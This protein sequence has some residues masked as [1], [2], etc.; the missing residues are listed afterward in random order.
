MQTDINRVKNSR[1]AN[2]NLC[3]E[4]LSVQANLLKCRK[5]VS[6]KNGTVLHIRPVRA[7]DVPG[8]GRFYKMLSG[9]SVFCRFASRRLCMSRDSLLRLCQVDFDR[10]FAFLAIVP[11]EKEHI[12]GEARLNRLCEFTSAE[13]SFVIADQWQGKGVG[14]LLMEFCLV[15]AKEIRLKK[16]LM[17]ILKTNVRMIQFGYK[18]DFQRLPCNKEDDTETLELRIGPETKLPYPLRSYSYGGWQS[19]RLM[20]DTRRKHLYH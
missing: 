12:I 8:L 9:V 11:G 18:Y 5:K 17:E 7:A 6:L 14:N 19:S 16:V 2:G 13:L 20:S 3:V 1:L 4:Q 10:D 15:V